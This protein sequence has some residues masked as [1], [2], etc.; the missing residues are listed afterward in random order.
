MLEDCTA[1]NQVFSKIN[2]SET[3]RQIIL[4]TN[5]RLNGPNSMSSCWKNNRPMQLLQL[6]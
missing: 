3:E 4:M 5:N 1:L 6:F 2:F